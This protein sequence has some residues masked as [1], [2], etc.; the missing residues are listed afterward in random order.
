MN[1]T[2]Y[3]HRCKIPE[4]DKNVTEYSPSW[5]ENAVPLRHN[6]PEKCFRYPSKMYSNS[7]AQECSFDAF[8]NTKQVKC[9]EFVYKTNE[10]TILNE[11]SCETSRV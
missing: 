9:D 6:E 4:C 7:S 10:V 3:V 1:L 5:L 8:D 11:V 2:F